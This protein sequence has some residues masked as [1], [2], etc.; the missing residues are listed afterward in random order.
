MKSKSS[1]FHVL[2]YMA[3]AGFAAMCA[4]VEPQ[5]AQVIQFGGQGLGNENFLL[6]YGLDIDPNNG[7]ILTCDTGNHQIKRFSAVAEYL[8]SFEGKGSVQGQFNSPQAIAF[9]VA[10]TVLYVL[11]TGNNRVQKLNAS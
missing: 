10:G 8:D 2:I 9:D 7:D 3:I 5:V 1:Q 6:P 4:A 11:D